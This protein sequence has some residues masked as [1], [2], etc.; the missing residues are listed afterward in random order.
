[1]NYEIIWGLKKIK[2]I[3]NRLRCFYI[4]KIRF[5]EEENGRK[6]EM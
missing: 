3:E 6:G 1:M 4:C 5:L 2:D